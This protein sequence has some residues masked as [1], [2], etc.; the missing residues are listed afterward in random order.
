[1]VFAL[2][3]QTSNS[4][5]SYTVNIGLVGYMNLKWRD[6][7]WTH[8]IEQGYLNSQVLIKLMESDCNNISYVYS[9]QKYLLI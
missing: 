3:T 2:V 1:M 6:K 4:N 8:L 9:N 7:P 5:H